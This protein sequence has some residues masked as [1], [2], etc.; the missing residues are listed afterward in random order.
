MELEN[1]LDVIFSHDLNCQKSQKIFSEALQTDLSYITISAI[2]KVEFYFI[3]LIDCF[4]IFLDPPSRG[5]CMVNTLW[6]VVLARK[7]QLEET[8]ERFEYC[9]L[10]T[11]RVKLRQKVF[12]WEGCWKIFDFFKDFEPKLWLREIANSEGFSTL[13]GWWGKD[14]ELK[15]LG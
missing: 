10:P 11:A 6:T 7:I 12:S 15:E 2:L 13:A 5:T 4:L 1:V 14:Q 3:G 9:W 8:W